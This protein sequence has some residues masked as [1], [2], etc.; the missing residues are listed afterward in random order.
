MERN[1]PLKRILYWL[2][3]GT[4]GGES[5]ARVIISLKE[6][7]KNANML[8]ESLG[9]EYKNVRHHLDVLVQNGLVTTVGEGYGMTYFLSNELEGNYKVFEEIWEKIGKSRKRLQGRRG[10]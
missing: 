2:I 4:R 10:K 6:M 9:M 3:A 1:A 8:A 7:P 5:R